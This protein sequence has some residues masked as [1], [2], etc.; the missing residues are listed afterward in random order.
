MRLSRTRRRPGLTLLEVIVSMAIFLIA[1][2]A[3]MEM[4]VT[5]TQWANHSRSRNQAALY[6]QSKINEVRVGALTL[7][8]RPE[9]PLDD[10][11]DFVWTMQ[12]QPIMLEG[13]LQVTVRVQ[14]ASTKPP[15]FV[16]MTQFIVDPAFQGNA[17]D[18][19]GSSGPSESGSE[20]SGGS[21][22]GAAGGGAG[23]AGAGGG[24]ATTPAAGGGA[25][26]PRIG[27]GGGGSPIG[28]GGGPMGGGGRPGGR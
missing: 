11:P 7:D 6:A 4:L 22:G 10:D 20:S 1:I 15:V 24:P 19:A 23:G 28:G 25:M 17:L 9:M 3:L 14:R 5:S 27:G 13:L 12:I 21:E 26:G 2:A 8:N 18:G 16:E